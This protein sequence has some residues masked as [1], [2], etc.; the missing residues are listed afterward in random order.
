MAALI[1]LMLLDFGVILRLIAA[2]L[3]LT[4]IGQ[5]GRAIGL[6]IGI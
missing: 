2:V 5:R 1:N 4:A 6:V 3:I